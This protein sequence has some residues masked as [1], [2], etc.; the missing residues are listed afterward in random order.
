MSRFAFARVCAR[1]GV[2]DDESEATSSLPPKIAEDHTPGSEEADREVSSEDE[3]VGLDYP[4]S[5]AGQREC[6]YTYRQ[7][8]LSL[9]QSPKLELHPCHLENW[10]APML[11][12]KTSNYRAEVTITDRLQEEL[13]AKPQIL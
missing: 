5:M 4:M 9:R 1:K 10:H 12:F 7:I 6:S 3:E 8:R 13:N 2:S 11:L